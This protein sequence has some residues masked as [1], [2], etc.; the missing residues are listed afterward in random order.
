M[1]KKISYNFLQNV[2]IGEDLFEGKSQEKIANV[3]A[4]NIVTGEFQNHSIYLLEN[5]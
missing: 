3:V 4:E 5:Y 1:E 2:P